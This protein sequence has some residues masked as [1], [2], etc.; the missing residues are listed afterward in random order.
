MSTAAEA[1]RGAAARP[2]SRSVRLRRSPV[3]RA[4][5]K[6]PFWLLIAA[7]FVYALFPFYWALRSAFT[8]EAECARYGGR[9][10]PG[11]GGYA[12]CERR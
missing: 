1:T 2:V 10:Y 4:L 12:F 7:I 8:P 11:G 5:I 3:G 6:V 9:W